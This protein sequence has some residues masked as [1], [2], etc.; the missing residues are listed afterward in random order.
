MKNATGLYCIGIGDRCHW[1]NLK[2]KSIS[3]GIASLG[4]RWSRRTRKPVGAS[5]FNLPAAGWFDR[6]DNFQDRSSGRMLQLV[7]TLFATAQYP[8]VQRPWE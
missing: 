5:W 3:R 7:P 1:P 4:A 8:Q 2:G 6:F